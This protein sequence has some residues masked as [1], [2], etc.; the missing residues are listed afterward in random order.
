HNFVG[1]IEREVADVLWCC[2]CL[3]PALAEARHAKAGCRVRM[4]R[5]SSLHRALWKAFYLPRMAWR[6]RRLYPL[7]ATL[8]SYLAPLSAPVVRTLWRE[9]P[10]AILVQDYASGK[11]DVLILFAR[12]LGI[13]LVAYHAGSAPERYQGSLLRRLTLRHADQ[14]LVSGRG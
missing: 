3:A 12:L 7:Y 9:R 1:L 6:W 4:L 5:S 8:A 10:D 11:F 13:P 2:V 14:L